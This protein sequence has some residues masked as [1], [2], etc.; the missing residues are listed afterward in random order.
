LEQ[1]QQEGEHQPGADE[2]PPDED[3]LVMALFYQQVPES[4]HDRREDDKGE[5]QVA[6]GTEYS[7]KIK[8]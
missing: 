5:G 8:F 2:H 1:E 4:M 3:G 6:H 7:E